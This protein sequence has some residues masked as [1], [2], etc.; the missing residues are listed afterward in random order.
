VHNIALWWPGL[1][2][3]LVVMLGSTVGRVGL[4]QAHGSAHAPTH[5]TEAIAGIP[6]GIHTARLEANC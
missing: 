1:V 4:H 5:A 3:S 2:V 6:A